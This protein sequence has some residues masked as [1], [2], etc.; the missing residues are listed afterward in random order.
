MGLQ[1]YDEAEKFLKQTLEFAHQQREGALG[2]I[3]YADLSTI[4]LRQGRYEEAVRLAR[5]ALAQDNDQDLAGSAFSSPWPLHLALGR[6]LRAGGH[7]KEAIEALRAAVGNI[8]AD[9]DELAG[10][11]SSNFRFFADK[12]DAY[13][14]LIE[15]LVREK[16]PSQAF[17]VAERM[18]GRTLVDAFAAK[19]AGSALTADERSREESLARRVNEINK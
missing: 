19:P 8:E 2:A 13:H 5:E 14:E 10:A 11:S 17:A 15:L 18:R 9:R 1:R 4:R 6:A 3:T 12:T 16:K 7:R